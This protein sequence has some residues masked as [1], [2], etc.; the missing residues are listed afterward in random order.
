MSTYRSNVDLPT[1]AA[2]LAEVRSAVVLSHAKPDGDALG[3]C[4]AMRRLLARSGATAAVVLVGPFDP[5]LRST[6][7]DAIELIDPRADEAA[8][9]AA[10][11]PHDEVE[12]IVVVDTGTYP[13]IEPLAAWVRE[14]RDRTIG[15]DHHA[16][17]DESLAAHRHV[18]PSAASTTE[19][20]ADLA[21]AMGVAFDDGGPGSLAE[22]IFM[23]LA[24]DTGWFRFPSAGARQFALAARLLEAGVDKNR[25]YALLEQQGRPERLEML[26]RGLASMTLV[27]WGGDPRQRFAVMHLRTADFEATG[28]A[29][30]D[31]SGLVNEPLSLAGVVASVML[32]EPEAGLVRMSFR[33]AG[34]AAVASGTAACDGAAIDVNELASRFGGGGH[35]AAA[36]A[37]IKA[38]MEEAIARVVAEIERGAVA[39]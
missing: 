25:L 5:A 7:S 3:S 21:S 14:R 24:T 10:L 12:A 4:L 39:R 20:L 29:S 11:A 34:A 38:P 13:Q 28:A 9:R 2:R 33:S 17:G 27:P 31:V 37:R 6:S 19:I 26:G 8:V 18:D 22:A 23:G 35:V 30:T 36:G 15:V 16:R 32:S 1:L